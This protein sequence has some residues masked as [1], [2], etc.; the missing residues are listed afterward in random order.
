MTLE[1][2]YKITKTKMFIIISG[3]SHIIVMESYA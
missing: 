3:N 1:N 2:G